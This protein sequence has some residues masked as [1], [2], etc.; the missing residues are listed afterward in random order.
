MMYEHCLEENLAGAEVEFSTLEL[1]DL[2]AAA[3]RLRLLGER[4]PQAS[5]ALV[6]R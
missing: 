4:L 2:T 5:L 6:G 1:A 3:S